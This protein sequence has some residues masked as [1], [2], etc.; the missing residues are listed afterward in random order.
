MSPEAIKVSIIYRSSKEI[1]E[2][3]EAGPR[4]RITFDFLDNLSPILSVEEAIDTYRKVFATT[5]VKS[6]FVEGMLPLWLQGHLSGDSRI[7]RAALSPLRDGDL[8]WSWPLFDASRTRFRE[9]GLW[10]E[11]WAPFKDLAKDRRRS[12][13]GVRVDLLNEWLGRRMLARRNAANMEPTSLFRRWGWFLWA[14]CEDDLRL[15]TDRQATVVLEDADTHP[16]FFPGDAS[17]IR[18]RARDSSPDNIR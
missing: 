12:L 2:A 5:T 9:I 13:Q 15:V 8:P 16:P 4:T 17:E 11:R 10:P 7:A 1:L 6:A 18:L 14:P 3:A